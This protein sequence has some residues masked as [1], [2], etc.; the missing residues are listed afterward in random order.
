M[1]NFLLRTHG[2][3]GGGRKVWV[4]QRQ[5]REKEGLCIGNKG[6]EESVLSSSC[7]RIP[8]LLVPSYL[9]IHRPCLDVFEM[10]WPLW[11]DSGDEALCFKFTQHR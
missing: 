4:E 11:Q 8:F 6:S 5:K 10:D 1:A 7:Q 3:K 2:K 9:G